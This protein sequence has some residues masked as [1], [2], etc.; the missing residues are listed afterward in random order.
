MKDVKDF[1]LLVLAMCIAS[2]AVISIF[3]AAHY[4]G[5]VI[6]WLIMGKMT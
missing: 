5:R 4:W 1:L 3:W 2:M 6:A